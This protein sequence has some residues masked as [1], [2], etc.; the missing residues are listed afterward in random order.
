[1]R[2]S[3]NCYLLDLILNFLMSL[4][5]LKLIDGKNRDIN[6]WTNF[7][8]SLLVTENAWVGNYH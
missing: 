4:I 2:F 1:M 6:Q 8:L 7:L 5:N 3:F